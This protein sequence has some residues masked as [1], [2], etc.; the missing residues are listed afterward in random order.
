MKT[1]EEIL[2]KQLEE[3]REDSRSAEA[4][5]DN[6][7]EK[8]VC[9]KHQKESVRSRSLSVEVRARVWRKTGLRGQR[10]ENVMEDQKRLLVGMREKRK[11]SF[12]VLIYYKFNLPQLC[13]RR[14]ISKKSFSQNEKPCKF[15]SRKGRSSS[16]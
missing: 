11:P 4:I 2:K 1:Q 3:K 15:M 10:E 8:R 14:S 7:W 12:L 6:I 16:E 9:K 13:K 5:R